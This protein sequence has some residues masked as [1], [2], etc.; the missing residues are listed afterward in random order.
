MCLPGQ[1]DYVLP[2][3]SVLRAGDEGWIVSQAPS[4]TST[5]LKARQELNGELR[6]TTPGIT[7]Y[8]VLTTISTPG[9][10]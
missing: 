6:W 7:E 8:G 10:F 9:F 2:I 3:L 5:K 4:T 1:Y